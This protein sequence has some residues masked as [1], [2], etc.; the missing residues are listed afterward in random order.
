MEYRVRC[1]D[2]TNNR[3][4]NPSICNNGSHNHPFQE[5]I[6]KLQNNPVESDWQHFPVVAQY[7]KKLVSH[8][9]TQLI[10]R[11]NKYDLYLKFGKT[12]KV[13][14]VGHLWPD[15]LF[16]INKAL[17]QEDLRGEHSRLVCRWVSN[18]ITVST[19][20]IFLKDQFNLENER[21][22]NLAQLAK[23]KQNTSTTVCPPS[24]IDFLFHQLK[25]SIR[26]CFCHGRTNCPHL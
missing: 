22:N 20:P 24:A 25:L 7:I 10:K 12:W 3:F 6:N 4:C 1:R 13:S 8:L 2:P 17:A 5:L 21:A 15:K 18:N 9:V 26:K 14:L 11:N 19:D 23:S 16:K